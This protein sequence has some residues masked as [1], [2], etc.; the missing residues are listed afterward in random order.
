VEELVPECRV[1][2]EWKVSKPE[3][4]SILVYALW[5]V[6]NVTDGGPELLEKVDLAYGEKAN[7]SC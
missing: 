2:C 5:D 7:D 1:V 3:V 6:H 4:L